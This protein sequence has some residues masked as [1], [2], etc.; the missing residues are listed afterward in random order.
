[1]EN[2]SIGWIGIGR[3]GAPMAERLLGAG[4]GVAI[5]N[6]TAS[7]AMPLKAK[8]AA[9]AD[10]PRDLASVDVLFTMVSTGADLE[11]V[12]FSEAGVLSGGQCPA[13]CVDCSSIGVEQSAA[14]RERLAERGAEFVASPVSGNGKCV[15]AGK[16]S[17][18]A[19]GPKAAFD[20]VEPL[21]SAVAGRGVAYVGEG[22]LARFCKIAHN[23]F[24]STIIH[25]LAEV[26]LLTNKAGVSR[27][28]FLE[29]INNSVLGS[30]FTQY[31]SNALVN[32]DWT[33]TFTPEL[34][35]KD[36]DLGL[37]AA[38]RHNVPM[39]VTAATRELLQ[40]H[41]GAAS[42]QDDPSEY[43][44]KDFAAILETMALASGMKLES[45][46]TPVP[47]GL[48]TASQD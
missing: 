37:E 8:G 43:L 3:M 2:L 28:A 38:R 20:K 6:R 24:L 27:A 42:L 14:I 13:I 21:I 19:S 5:W 48:E 11:Q 44:S 22:E 47:T 12:Y 25:N 7:K 30:I 31:K 41:F 36:I 39:P 33:T 23:V 1:M 40:S 15:K 46:E 9:V 45:E 17:A 35:R 10:K 18:V 34:L 26:T 4:H 16:M 32:L 29:F